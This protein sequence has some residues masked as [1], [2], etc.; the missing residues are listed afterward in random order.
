MPSLIKQPNAACSL[1]SLVTIA[2]RARVKPRWQSLLE[3]GARDLSLTMR[4]QRLIFC[5]T[6]TI[7]LYI[8]GNKRQTAVGESQ[9]VPT[10]RMHCGGYGGN[11][12]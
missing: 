5:V 3:P 11:A 8:G 2:P 10:E 7:H 1:F 12:K 9:G 6:R 4:M